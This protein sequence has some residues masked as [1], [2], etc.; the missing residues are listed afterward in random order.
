MAV[1]WLI[2]LVLYI[3]N[4]K[5]WKLTYDMRNAR[6]CA[7]YV[8]ALEENLEGVLHGVITKCCNGMCWKWNISV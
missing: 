6:F 3:I 2:G 8:C 7:V 4:H 1:M 5:M